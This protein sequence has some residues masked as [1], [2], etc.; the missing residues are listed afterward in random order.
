MARSA[1]N[2]A[3]DR[4]VAGM[5]LAD[6]GLAKREDVEAIIRQDLAGKSREEVEA[7][8]DAIKNSMTT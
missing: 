4:A 1:G 3:A 5:W 2:A 7:I 6:K 8:R